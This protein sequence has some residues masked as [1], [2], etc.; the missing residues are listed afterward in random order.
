MERVS[1]QQYLQFFVSSI[2]R[3]IYLS[4]SN[5]TR[6]SRSVFTERTDISNNEHFLVA[7]FKARAA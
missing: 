1:L 7:N 4:I 5:I 2:I 3:Y 6:W